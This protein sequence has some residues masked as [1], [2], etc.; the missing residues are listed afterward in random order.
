MHCSEK[1]GKP[2]DLSLSKNFLKWR[3][4][5]SD[6]GS[7]IFNYVVEYKLSDSFKWVKA[8]K[9]GTYHSEC[10]IDLPNLDF[11]NEIY[12]LRVAA[13]NEAGIGNFSDVFTT[14]KEEKAKKVA[15][16]PEISRGLKDLSILSPEKITLKVEGKL[17]NSNISWYRNSK[18][19]YPGGKVNITST[20]DSSVLI[21][22]DA[23]VNDEGSYKVYVSSKTGNVESECKVT[24]KGNRIKPI[25][26]LFN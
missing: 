22:S 2:T 12:E 19:I 25:K 6:G 16:S 1:P 3:K 9:D 14:V 24:V 23:Q 17:E 15:K 26:R 7:D 8:T 5:N 20:A 4:P 13:E 10:E 21:I 18:E 11:K